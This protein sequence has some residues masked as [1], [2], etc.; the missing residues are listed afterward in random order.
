MYL[1][2]ID[3]EG[4]IVLHKNIR[5]R[6]ADFMRAVA[7]FQ[8]GLAVACECMFAWYWIADLCERQEIDFVL[9]HALYMRAIYGAKTKNERPDAYKIAHLLR[10]GNFPFEPVHIANTPEST[11]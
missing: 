4:E 5:T 3:V 6:C 9:G 11:T 1:C 8:E 2:I 7:P 10:G